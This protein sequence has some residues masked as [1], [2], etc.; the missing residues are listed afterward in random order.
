VAPIGAA[1]DLS[2]STIRGWLPAREAQQQ[3]AGNK[4]KHRYLPRDEE[5]LL[6]V[7]TV[8]RALRERRGGRQPG[9]GGLSTEEKDNWRTLLR[10]A[11]ADKDSHSGD[12]QGEATNDPGEQPPA[13]PRPTGTITDDDPPVGHGSTSQQ[14]AADGG[15]RPAST[16]IFVVQAP[17]S[18]QLSGAPAADGPTES[19]AR[20]GWLR[21]TAVTALIVLVLFA[22]GACAHLVWL[23]NNDEQPP[24]SPVSCAYVIKEPADVYSEPDTEAKVGKSKIISEGVTVLGGPRPQGWVPLSTPRD[25]SRRAWMRAEVLSSPTPRTGTR[26]PGT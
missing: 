25:K 3:Q 16:T 19:P 21:R 17:P 15:A 8:L 20:W 10:E 5:D 13:Q 11:Q 24:V 23:R 12:Q 2:E 1:P 22:V 14:A 7:I 9:R 4:P 18:L 26:C 6:L